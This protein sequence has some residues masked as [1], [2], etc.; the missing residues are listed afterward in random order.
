MKSTRVVLVLSSII[1]IAVCQFVI[2]GQVQTQPNVAVVEI[3]GQ[4]RFAEGGAPAANVVVRLESYD[5][6]G[7]ISE[8][9]TDR[10]GKFRFTNLPPAQYS[11]RVRQMGYR[12]ALQNVDM[13]TTTSGLVMLQLLRDSSSSTA[14]TSAP[15]SIDVNVPPAAQKEF[16]K[17]AAALAEGGKDKTAFATRCFEKAVSIYPKFVEARLKLGTAYMDLEQWDKAEKAL[18]G[19]VEVDPKA[20]NALFALS[21]IYLRQNKIGE[22]EKVLVQ[23][24]AIQDQSYLGHLN[25]ARV[26]WERARAVKDLGQA[27]PVL[28]K[29]YEE[30]K[31]ALTLNPDLAGAH[32]LKGNLLLRVP[33]TADALVEFNE[34]LRLEP[35]G[36]FAAE[37]RA[38]IE[39]I[40]HR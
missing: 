18:L 39:K 37:T 32:L 19:T 27:K 36:P 30:V 14:T 17:G 7:S 3:H 34:Y 13:T 26:Y 6:G 4:V 15:G 38:L 5:G 28:E 11:V 24:L 25:L 20:F 12:D 1:A 2:L 10:L 22:A 31:R 33:R 21:E 35:N 8:A 23:G 9:F 29:S 16:D 40:N